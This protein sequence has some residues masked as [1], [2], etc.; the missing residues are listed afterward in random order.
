M[1]GQQ[2][3]AAQSV[4]FTS[5]AWHAQQVLLHRITNLL[6]CKLHTVHGRL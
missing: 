6:G 4:P 5:S 1:F 2:R 3:G